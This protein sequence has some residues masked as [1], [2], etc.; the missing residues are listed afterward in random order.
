M[1]NEILKSGYPFLRIA[2]KYGVDY[3]DVLAVADSIQ[4]GRENKG[5]P[6]QDH[7]FPAAMFDDIFEACSHFLGIQKGR[8]PFP[9]T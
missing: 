3:S 5:R 6:I 8:I 2:Q 1:S 9:G 4:H 7:L